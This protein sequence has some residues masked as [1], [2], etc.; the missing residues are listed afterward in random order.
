MD[1]KIKFACLNE[2]NKIRIFDP[3]SKYIDPDRIKT[4]IKNREVIIAVKGSNIIG[5]L[6]LSYFWDTRPYIG[7][8]LVKKDLRGSGIGKNMLHF[9]EEYLQSKNYAYLFSS[10]EED[11]LESHKWH[12]KNGFKKCGKINNLN[13]PHREVSEIFFCK[14]ISNKPG[15]EDKLQEYGI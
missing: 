2:F 6:K 8:I 3:D 7:L 5:L 9:L 4:K 14:K 11:A 1:Y 13:L 15:N 10:S 12:L